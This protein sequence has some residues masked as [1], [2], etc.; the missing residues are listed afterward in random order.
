M[1]VS[2]SIYGVTAYSF[3]VNVFSEVLVWLENELHGML[4]QLPHLVSY[5]TIFS[6]LE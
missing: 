5:K 6:S 4:E 3:D 2:S 1:A